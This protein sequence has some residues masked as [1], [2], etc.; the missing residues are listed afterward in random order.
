MVLER[1][2]DVFLYDG[3]TIT[4]LSNSLYGAGSAQINDDGLVVWN[5]GTPDYGSQYSYGTDNKK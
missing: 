1:P 4:N 5:E 2:G 3:L